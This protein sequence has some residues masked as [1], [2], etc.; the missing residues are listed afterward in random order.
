MSPS[1][2]AFLAG[3]GAAS[4]F[5][6]LPRA[7]RAASGCPF[8]LAVISDEISQDFDH[9]CYVAAHDF[10]MR[11]I[12]LRSM[13]DKNVTELSEAQIADQLPCRRR[14]ENG[15]DARGIE[16]R[17]PAEAE[18]LCPGGKPKRMDGHHR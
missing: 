3:L 7:A 6:A 16:D 13:W 10:G 4:A 5:A 8:R 12:E 9:A 11:W 2:R 17:H 14:F 15:P 18:A 1:R